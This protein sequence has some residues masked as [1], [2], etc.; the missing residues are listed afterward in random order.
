[1][2]DPAF[3]FYPGDWLGGTMGMTFEEKGAYMELLILQFNRG[4]MTKHMIAQTIGQ[5]WVNL[6]DKFEVDSEGKYFNAR[7]DIEKQRRKDFVKSRVNN[8][9][10]TN[11]YTKKK[12]KKSGHMSSHME[13]EDKDEN[14]DINKTEIYPTFDDFWDEYDKK[15]GKKP[16]VK[17]EWDKLNYDTKNLIMEYIPYYK[18]AQP[19]KKYRKNPETFLNNESW[20][21]E[22]I[23]D[24][25]RNNN[26]GKPIGNDF[27]KVLKGIDDLYGKK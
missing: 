1:M 19:N 15:V 21:D 17:K 6:E 20:N 12:K 10:G 4:H 27:N 25:N 2:K 5:L 14:E 3:L 9:L 24:E 7:L 26:N 22:I 18:Q 8:I 13:N 16:K 11:Q 23:T